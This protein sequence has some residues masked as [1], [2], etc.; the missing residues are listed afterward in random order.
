MCAGYQLRR[1][2]DGSIRFWGR[3]GLGINACTHT[4]TPTEREKSASEMEEVLKKYI[5]V[6][7]PEKCLGCHCVLLHLQ[8]RRLHDTFV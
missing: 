4:H 2:S 6:S 1:S 8:N 5:S 7:C 3:G